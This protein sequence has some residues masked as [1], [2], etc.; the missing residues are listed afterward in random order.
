MCTEIKR[1]FGFFL[2]ALICICSP[3]LSAE[4]PEAKIFYVAQDGND[5]WTGSLPAT[6]PEKN[7]GPFAS[8]E[9][10]RD[11]VRDLAKGGELHQIIVRVRGGI[12]YLERPFVL[13]SLDSGSPECHILYEAYPGEQVILSGGRKIDA[14][15][16]PYKD[17]IMVCKVPGVAEGEW[18]FHQL[19]VNGKRQTRAR[20]PNIGEGYFHIAGGVE[21][22]SEKLTSFKFY[23][24]DL[25][26]WHN[27]NDVVIVNYRSWDEAI[28][29]IQ[30][31]DE[32]R[33]IVHF[34]GP[35]HTGWGFTF[36]RD[37]LWG[38]QRYHVENV[39]EGLDT[40]G[41]WYLDR[42]TGELFYYPP[43]GDNINDCVVTAPYLVELIRVQGNAEEKSIVQ[44]VTFSGFTMRETEW[45]LPETGYPGDQAD[46]KLPS[47]LFFEGVEHCALK[48]NIMENIGTY[49]ITFG[50]R[51]RYN[52]I[53]GNE[54]KNIGAGSI[55]IGTTDRNNYFTKCNHISNNHI[56]NCGVIYNGA[57]GIWIG[58][59]SENTISHNEIHDINYSGISVGWT[60]NSADNPCYGNVFEYN[61]IYR[62]MKNANDGAGIYTLGKQAGTI[63]RNN[64][65]HDIA[66]YKYFGWGIYFDG[67]SANITVMNNILYRC[68]WGSAMCP[69]GNPNLW[70]NNILV[71]S[72][73]GQLFW[74]AAAR[75]GWERFIQ[76][77]I[78][79][80]DPDAYLIHAHSGEGKLKEKMGEMDYNLYYCS[81]GNGPEDLKIKGRG[82]P[83]VESPGDWQRLGFDFHSIYA[84][85]LF[86]DPEHDDYTLKPESPAFKL[87]FKQINVS[88][89]G[90][91]NNN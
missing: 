22:E 46:V 66:P 74:M 56:F 78:Y 15:W 90:R 73:R 79:Y 68:E 25:K 35:T 5:S 45:N 33:G 1:I 36:A 19:F 84:D 54:I 48:N 41:E 72:K 29:R 24:G 55:R 61:K 87:G 57:V 13:S 62:V 83:E 30:D 26:R 89:V 67:E 88:A 91:I 86:V 60:W 7:D 10:A 9:K 21:A 28:L 47:A 69:S 2:L 59:S 34:T 32:S 76:N 77:I 75:L 16:A 27:L 82:I 44:N 51:C 58:Q 8:L 17:K 31:I 71:N 4:V 52:T 40:A 53:A 49:A 3:T 6:N 65:I 37:G 20:I 39:L 63:I 50:D 43:E 80:S 70:I 12:H 64:I 23:P 14:S 38:P 81:R 85:P 18:Y 11:T 42:H